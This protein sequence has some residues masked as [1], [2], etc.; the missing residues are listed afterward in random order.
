VSA[1]TV[2]D[3]LHEDRFCLR[4]NVKTIEG[5]QYPERAVQFRYI[6]ELAKRYQAA[7]HPVANGGKP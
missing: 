3:L 6:N 1:D 5:S 2:G 7:G 4:G